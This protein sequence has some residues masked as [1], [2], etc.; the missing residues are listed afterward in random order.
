[1][2]SRT[3]VAPR[4]SRPDTVREINPMVNVVIHNTA[5]TDNI[6]DTSASTT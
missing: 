1:M 4:P 3:S 5:L 2:V 6:F